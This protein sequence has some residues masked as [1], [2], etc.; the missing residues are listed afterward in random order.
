MKKLIA[1]TVLATLVA[2]CVSTH[3]QINIFEN[4]LGPTIPATF[5]GTFTGGNYDID[6][7]ANLLN[8]LDVARSAFQL[9]PPTPNV[10][11]FVSG[12][13]VVAGD[14]LI[15]H[16]NGPENTV[17]IPGAPPITITLRGG[18]EVLYFPD[19]VASFVIPLKSSNDTI[20]PGEKLFAKLF[21][22][23]GIPTPDGGA[24]LGLLGIG[25]SAL[26]I[27]GRRVRRSK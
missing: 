7:N 19:D 24:T 11:E 14:Y 9:P 16:Y 27:A 21:D 22:H 3:A 10:S 15:L 23:V 26:G 2:F 25:V 12:S 1:K 5:V 8:F 17:V 13:P 4:T 18:I 20:A 6:D